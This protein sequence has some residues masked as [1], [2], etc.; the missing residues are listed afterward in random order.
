MSP[1]LLIILLLFILIIF[2]VVLW[3]IFFR[4]NL[5]FSLVDLFKK[6]LDIALLP[7]KLFI[8]LFTGL[9]I[10]GTP[11]TSIDTSVK[12]LPTI[13]PPTEAPPVEV[14]KH[15]IATC[16]P[17]NVKCPD[18][19]VDN[20]SGPLELEIK[21]LKDMLKFTGSI[22]KRENAINSQYREL[23]PGFSVNSPEV[24]RISTEYNFLKNQ[25]RDDANEFQY[26]KNYFTKL[27]GIPS[28]SSAVHYDL[29][30]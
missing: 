29:I 26:F 17:C 10:F 25:I 19:P 24:Q 30:V 20:K 15:E 5:A 8:K 9:N 7:F 11:P 28:T 1:V 2:A 4:D 16:P 6:I 3:F 22:C 12:P 23:Y 21:Y 18:V 13:A 27:T 14:V